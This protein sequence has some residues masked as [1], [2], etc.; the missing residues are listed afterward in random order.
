MLAKLNFIR[1][2]IGITRK[3]ID[4]SW[5]INDIECAKAGLN[6]IY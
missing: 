5:A 1:V 4:L 3:Y 6:L 2:F